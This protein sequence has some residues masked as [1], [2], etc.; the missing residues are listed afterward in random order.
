MT[1]D[2]GRDPET[3]RR[4]QARRRFATEKAAR[5]EL[6]AVR[7][8]T[9]AGTYVQ[10][11]KLT[12]D[13]ACEAWLASK[14]ALKPSTL[15]GHRVSLQPMRD[16]LG[17]IMLYLSSAVLDDQ[18]KQGNV[19]R[20]VAALVDR[21][22]RDAK[23]FH[24]LTEAEVFPSSTTIVAIGTCG[25]LA[26]HGMR[27]G[28]IAGRRWSSVNLTDKQIGEGKVGTTGAIGARRGEPRGSR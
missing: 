1:V 20:N 11:S 6:A 9:V 13:Q 5:A 25:A 15:R 26:L 22:S 28:E 3:A 4:R 24:T 16:D 10:S 19:V 8:G 14:H 27:R 21:V 12:V 23:G 7:G 2:A 17:T 18:L